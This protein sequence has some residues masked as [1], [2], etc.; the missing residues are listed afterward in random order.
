MTAKMVL[1][2]LLYASLTAMSTLFAVIEANILFQ[3][4]TLLLNFEF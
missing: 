3:L 4:R 1:M 2:W